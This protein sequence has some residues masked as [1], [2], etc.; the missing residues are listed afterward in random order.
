MLGFWHSRWEAGQTGWHEPEG[1]A[2]LRKYWPSLSRGSRVLVPLCGKSFD[3]LWLAEQGCSVTGVELSEIAAHAF[4]NEAGLAFETEYKN[5]FNWFR[6]R[7]A[8]IDIACGNYFTFVDQ[9]FDALFD[10]AAL[11][12]LPAKKRTEY[13]LQTKNLLKPDASQLLLTIEF[14][15]SVVEGPPFSV[16]PDEVKSHWPGL[17]RVHEQDDIDNSPPR[18][19]D[20]GIEEVLEVVWLGRHRTPHF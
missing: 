11:V 18:F 19:R 12:A 2:A 3:L 5:G 15:Q 1:N 9:P 4:F 16:M 6:C 10:R 8:N 13:V 14:D 20:A 7:E 17:E